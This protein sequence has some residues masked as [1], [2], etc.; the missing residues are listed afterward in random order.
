MLGFSRSVS[1]AGELTIS[2]IELLPDPFLP[3]YPWR[4]HFQLTASDLLG[5]LQLL[6]RVLVRDPKR[7]ETF[8][9]Q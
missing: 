4:N 1:S 2:S 5:I 7:P 9:I 6:V 8:K 3:R